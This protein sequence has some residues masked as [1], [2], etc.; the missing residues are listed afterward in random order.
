MDA[1]YI[2]ARDIMREPLIIRLDCSVR[3]AAEII[4]NQGV[5]ALVVVENEK[6]I[7]VV[8]K[9]DLLWFLTHSGRDPGVESV[10]RIMSKNL[11]SVD[12]DAD[13]TVVI[14]KMLDNNISHIVVIED[15][16]LVGIISD[17][18]IIELFQNI[19]EYEKS[20]AKTG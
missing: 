4:L 19:L 8:T 6:P 12:P 18:E 14:E 20:I 17:R 5:G 7:G 16:K 1:N 10:D 15:N 3:E 13:I 11:I 2:K 9:R